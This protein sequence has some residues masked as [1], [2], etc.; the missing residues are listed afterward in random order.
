M[1][2]IDNEINKFITRKTESM[3]PCPPEPPPPPNINFFFNNQMT[4]HHKNDEKF[5]NNITEKYIKS[6]DPAKKVKLIIFYRN[7]KLLNLFIKNKGNFNADPVHDHHVVYQFTCD[8][9]S[10]NS[11]KYIGYTTCSLYQRFGC[12]TQSGSIRKHLTEE[13][14]ATSLRRRELLRSTEVLHR[15]NCRRDLIFMEALLIKEN[16][17]TLNAQDEGCEKILK[18]FKH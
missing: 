15:S 6:V 11:N 5:L 4:S 3:Q 14:G 7:R 13:H 18:I 16:N 8:Y 9:E 10:C 12:H 2:I 1:K 17:P